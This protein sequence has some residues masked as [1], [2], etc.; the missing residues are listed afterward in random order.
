MGSSGAS[1]LERLN[2][3]ATAAAA[4]RASGTMIQISLQGRVLRVAGAATSLPE[5][6]SSFNSC[7]AILTSA[8]VCQRRAGSLRRQRLM[9]RSA[10]VGKSSTI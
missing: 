1:E 9:I 6:D 3:M 8:M 4:R 2:H 7:S 5:S 10:S